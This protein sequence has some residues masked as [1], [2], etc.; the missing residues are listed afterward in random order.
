MGSIPVGVAVA[1]ARIYKSGLDFDWQNVRLASAWSG[2]K[3]HQLKK[4]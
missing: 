1:Y 4:K 2:F 3:S